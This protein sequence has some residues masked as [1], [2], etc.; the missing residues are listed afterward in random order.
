MSIRHY[1]M[2]VSPHSLYIYPALRTS[3]ARITLQIPK[4]RYN[5][6]AHNPGDP[7]RFG[8]NILEGKIMKIP[9]LVDNNTSTGRYFVAEPG[10]SVFIERRSD[11]G[12]L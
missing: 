11:T 3:D 5:R 12:P 9:V 4:C 8:R 7:L 1:L 10:L 2:I 6:T